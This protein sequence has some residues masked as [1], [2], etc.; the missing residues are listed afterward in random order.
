VVDVTQPEH[1]TVTVD[2]DGNIVY[3]PKEGYVGTDSFT[4]TVSDGKG[5]YATATVT[6][7]V[8]DRDGDGIPD[9]EEEAGC[10]D[11]DNADSDGDGLSD[12]DEAGLPEGTDPCDADSDDDGLDDGTETRGD[13]VLEGVGPLNPLSPDTDGDGIQDGTELGLTAPVPAGESGGKPMKGTDAASFVPDA[14][15][16]TTTDPT[17]DDSDD[18]G[19]LDGTEDANG[20]G[21]WEGEIGGT[22]T[23]G[24]G[25]TDPN[26]ADTDG[27]GLQDGTESGLTAPEGDDTDAAV[28]VPDADPE[29][30][31]D[32]RDTDTDDGSVIDGDEDGNHNGALEA[33]E[34]DPNVTADDAPPY[35]TVAGGGCQQGGGSAVPWLF[36]LLGLLFVARRRSG[37][38]A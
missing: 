6:I 24:S 17:D 21:A 32:P 29:T 25:E 35:L 22:G 28:F 30:T 3:T 23:A 31:T 38:R 10:S 26:D 11:P 37:A 5:G 27:D 20:N 16:E 4:Y 13:G 12:A 1:G 14:D 36:A 18:D 34:K 9:G 2:E 15:P 8:G 33:G 19:L 7:V